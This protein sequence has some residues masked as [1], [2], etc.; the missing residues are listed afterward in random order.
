MKLLNEN[1]FILWN[2]K[3]HLTANHNAKK[4]H[5]KE[6]LN[7][8]IVSCFCEPI[9]HYVYPHIQLFKIQEFYLYKI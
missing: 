1:L 6:S 5:N 4:L 2:Y 7:N 9:G 3:R 8:E